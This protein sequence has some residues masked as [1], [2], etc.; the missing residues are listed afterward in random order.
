MP[1]ERT[2]LF[3][4]LFKISV[5]SQ[6]DRNWILSGLVRVDDSSVSLGMH[7]IATFQTVESNMSPS[8]YLTLGAIVKQ[9]KE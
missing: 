2:E 9:E 1:F 8:I 7:D 4:V 3:H 5:R 6:A